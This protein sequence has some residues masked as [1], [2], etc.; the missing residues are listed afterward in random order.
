MTKIQHLSQSIISKI[1]AGEVIE[2]PVYAVKELVENALDAGADSVKVIIE[3]SGLKRITVI[4]NGEGMTVE[5][6]QECFKPHTT[7]KLSSEDQLHA[8]RTLGFRGEALSSIAAISTMTI[9]SRHKDAPAGNSVRIIEGE[10]EK[11][12]PI[13][14]PVGTQVT[15]ENLF[16]PVPA[17]K[18]FLKSKRTEF[19]HILDVLIHFAF[20]HPSVQLTLVHNGKTIFDLPKTEDLL[21]RMQVLLE[22]DIYANMIPVTF[23]DGYLSLSGFIA[24]PQITTKTPHKQ[25]FFINNRKIWDKNISHIL[26]SSYGTLL[27]KQVY[28]VAILFLSMPHEMLDVNVHPRKEEVKFIDTQAVLSAIESAVTQSLT[29]N[30][31]FFAASSWQSAVFLGDTDE[32]FSGRSTHSFAGK[33]LKEQQLPWTLL[34]HQS[35]DLSKIMQIHNLYIMTHTKDGFALI[36]QHAA[37]ERIMYEQYREAFET[38][39]AQAAIY[40]FSTP[41]ILEFSL[42]ESELLQEYESHFT[43]LGFSVEYF[44]GKSFLIRSVPQ[45]FKDRDQKELISEILKN[46]RMDGDVAIDSGSKKMLAYLACRSA[47]K[48]GDMLREDQCRDLLEQLEKTPNNATCPHGRPTK[49]LVDLGML[50]KMFKRG[51]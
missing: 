9:S 19:R 12:M 45:L 44:K 10:V 36:D 14:I 39:K 25:F 26:K 6:L 48:A 2:R 51:Y 37:H 11:M 46:L 23:S 7:S 13:G 24:R 8:I 50:H 18:K 5:D 47:V 30:N 15:V 16:G 27:E 20:S 40:T 1:A 17:R 21:L 31:L 49:V 35:S 42:L 3:D 43:S 34:Q 38:Q 4:D 22:K 32:P 28:P 41:K 33:L 29:N